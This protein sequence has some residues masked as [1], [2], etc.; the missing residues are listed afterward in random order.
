MAISRDKARAA[1]RRALRRH[2][3]ADELQHHGPADV[4]AMIDMCL[5]ET[6]DVIAHVVE[7]ERLLRVAWAH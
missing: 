3:T 5:G 1:G 6:L 7:T 4:S 2:F